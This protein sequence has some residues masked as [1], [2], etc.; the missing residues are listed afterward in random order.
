MRTVV[1]DRTLPRPY[2]GPD[3][4]ARIAVAF[5]K[6]I[7]LPSSELV[8]RIAIPIGMTGLQQVVVDIA[9]S[10]ADSPGAS[11]TTVRAYGKEGLLSRKPTARTADQIVSVL[12]S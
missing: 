8:L 4:L 6:Y 1:E 11:G 2:V 3:A 5:P 12:S 9:P 7:A 10:G